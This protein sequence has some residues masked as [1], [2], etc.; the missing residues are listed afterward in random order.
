MT[1]LRWLM[2]CACLL[3]GASG[4][5]AQRFRPVDGVE[6]YVQGGRYLIGTRP[7]GGKALM[8]AE[9]KELSER[10]KAR[11]G[12]ALTATSDGAFETEGTASA[13]FVLEFTDGKGPGGKFRLRDEATGGLLCYDTSNKG[14]NSNNAYLYTRAEAD[15]VK[16]YYATFVFDTTDERAFITTAESIKFSESS[17]RLYYLYADKVNPVF[18]LYPKPGI[19]TNI[20]LYYEVQPP[21]LERNPKTHV[22]TL[23]GEWTAEQ[24]AALD[25]SRRTVTDLTEADIHGGWEAECRSPLTYV[26]PGQLDSL[27]HGWPNV[28]VLS[29]GQADGT[30]VGEAVT[31]IR[32]A[33][34]DTLW[35][36]YAFGVT[37]ACPLR[38]ERKV[39][40][41]GGWHS[42]FLP[43]AVHRFTVADG[44][45]A[46]WER[47]ALASW[48][49]EGIV[50]TPVEAGTAQL[51]YRPFLLRGPSGGSE[52]TLVFEG[53]RQTVQA[54]VGAMPESDSDGFCFSGTLIG[55][56][57]SGEKDCY[58][59]EDTGTGF[60]RL[61]GDGHL[62]PFRAC[63]Y[64]SKAP[65]PSVCSFL[66]DK[67]ATKTPNLPA[68]KAQNRFGVYTISGR[69][70]GV[71]REQPETFTTW[72]RGLY[73]VGGRKLFAP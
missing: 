9:Q 53:H 50:L 61:E 18:K 1:V 10:T 41:D 2:V 14:N 31:P 20:T 60:A 73:I 3:G 47:W 6:R 16:P 57:P 40:A 35:V 70:A 71:F 67:T 21:T 19:A 58:A 36:P 43:F 38:Y 26:R 27:P 22:T 63:I 49:Q 5:E 59:L 72:P 25:W 46:D 30:R 69:R 32:W 42:V 24:L 15:I 45:E 17:S 62:R 51:P 29:E 11:A 48:V 28:V 8:M 13:R 23:R 34:G 7:S 37:D 66:Y 56:R 4:L 33:D 12:V 54:A 65:G 52:V 44:C 68:G 64:R 55:V 39:V